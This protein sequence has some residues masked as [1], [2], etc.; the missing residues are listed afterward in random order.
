MKVIIV[1]G[2]SRGIGLAI[3]KFLLDK[4]CNVVAVARSPGGLEQLSQ[5]YPNSL[6]PVAADLSELSWGRQII[7][8]AVQEWGRLDGL[9]LNHGT[10]VPVKRVSDTTA[11]DWREAFDVNFFSAVAL[12][13]PAIPELRKTGGRIIVTSSGAAVKA[14]TAWGAYGATKAALNHL[15]STLAVEERTITSIAVRPG[16]VDTQMQ[17]D[18]REFHGKHMDDRDRAKFLELKTD[19]Q[20]LRPEQPGHVIAK[21]VLEATAELS[22]RFITWNDH[23]LANFQ[24]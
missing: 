8:V 4:R 10:L 18:L 23:D 2:A 24:E 1:T 15:V 13:Q 21:L 14:Y 9:V 22:G 7:N 12:L 3:T 16:V 5:Q 19:G 17:F 11:Q 20:L 6:K